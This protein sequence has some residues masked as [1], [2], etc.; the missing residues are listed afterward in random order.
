MDVYIYP[1]SQNKRTDF[2]KDIYEAYFKVI[3]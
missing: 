2:L 1:T 3:N